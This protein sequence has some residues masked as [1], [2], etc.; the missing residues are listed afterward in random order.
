MSLSDKELAWAIDNS[1]PYPYEWPHEVYLYMAKKLKEMVRVERN[2]DDQGWIYFD[3]PGYGLDEDL[4]R[5][6]KEVL[7]DKRLSA[8]K[9]QSWLDAIERRQDES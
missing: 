4:A 5:L 8:N 1:T 6:K 9:R 3:D 7:N 2:E